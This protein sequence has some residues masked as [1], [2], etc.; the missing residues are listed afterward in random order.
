MTDQ[1][2][3]ESLSLLMSR[4]YDSPPEKVFE[5]WT[6]PEIVKQ[7]WGNPEYRVTMIEIDLR[8]GGRKPPASSGGNGLCVRAGHARRR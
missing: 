7:W 2:K 4:Q 5:A 1:T 6:N 3:P 8:V